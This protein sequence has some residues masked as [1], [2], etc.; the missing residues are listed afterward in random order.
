MAVDSAYATPE[1]YRKAFKGVSSENDI[2]VTSDLAAVARFIEQ[3]CGRFFNVDAS[4]VTRVYV[5]GER[6]SVIQAGGAEMVIDDL[7][8]LTTI[9]VDTDADGS[10]SD[11]TA[12]AATD[13]E[14]LPRNA[15]LGSEAQPYTSIGVPPWSLQSGFAAGDRVQVVGKFGWPA[16][17]KAV[18]LAN[19]RLCSMLRGESTF[20]TDRVVEGI[21]VL[22]ESNQVARGI[23]R[24]L[25]D[26]YRKWAF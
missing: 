17:P 5:A 18:K 7:V 11:E 8:S 20:A 13:Y 23:M 25:V 4:D 3:R 22:V 15:L 16:V 9:K 26:P 12:W 21:G 6:P 14:L 1:E 2:E 19:L 10:F 24:D